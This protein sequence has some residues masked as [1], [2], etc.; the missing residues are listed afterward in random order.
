MPLMRSP[1][2]LGMLTGGGL[3]ITALMVGAAQNHPQVIRARQF[4]VVDEIGTVQLVLGTNRQG[5]SLSVRDRLGRTVL[6]FAT[7]DDSGAMVLTH[8]ELDRPGVVLR[9]TSRGGSMSLN[10]QSGH[11]AVA[12]GASG[13]ESLRIGDG[14]GGTA[15]TIGASAQGAASMLAYGAEG[16]RLASLSSD[17][18]GG[19]LI[20]TYVQGRPLVT[21]SST[22]GGH[23]QI[24]T[25]GLE[26]QALAMLTATGDDQGQF[27]TFASDGRPLVALA[28]RPGGP[29]ARVYNANGDPAVTIETDEQGRGI[30]G[31]WREDGTGRVLEP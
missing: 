9:A 1:F 13:E 21:L 3:V 30:I 6:L 4:E 5:G 12:A 17:A 31:L 24:K 26:G 16:R 27:Y 29:T 23:G 2:W 11:V 25:M 8:P 18:A 7:A 19:G 10:D 20:E 14:R 22:I 28:S 15:M